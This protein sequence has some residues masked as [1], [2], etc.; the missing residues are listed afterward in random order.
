MAEG[1]GKTRIKELKLELHVDDEIRAALQAIVDGTKDTLELHYVYFRHLVVDDL[2]HEGYRVA[3][4]K[5]PLGRITKVK[6]KA[7]NRS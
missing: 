4:L 6:L 3:Q 1:A 2:K 7:I 5:I